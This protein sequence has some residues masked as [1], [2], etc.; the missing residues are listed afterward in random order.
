MSSFQTLFCTSTQNVNLCDIAQ[1]NDL[2]CHPFRHCLAP[3][4]KMSVFTTLLGTGT[5]DVIPLDMAWHHTQHVSLCNIA[6]EN[7]FRYHSF[8]H[9]YA[10]RPK[11][12]VFTTLLRKK[13]R[14]VII[15][16]IAWYHGPRCQSLQHCSRKQPKMSHVM[17][18]FSKSPQGVDLNGIAK[19]KCL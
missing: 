11:M 14:D 18:L 12:L 16:N 2:R 5:C 10:P 4:P 6:Q 1:H 3:W 9:C 17:T 8:K 15:L 19:E 13:A 7:G